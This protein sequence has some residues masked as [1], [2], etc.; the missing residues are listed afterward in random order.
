MSGAGAIVDDVARSQLVLEQD[1]SPAGAK[2]VYRHH[3]D[4]LVLVHTEVP[5]RLGGRG[6]GGQ[7][8]RAAVEQ[9]AAGGLTVVPQCSYARHW[10]EVHPDVA[11]TVAVDWTPPPG[12]S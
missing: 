2:L 8:V 12:P 7:L 9:A 4:R 11:G 3:G 1:G 6:I 10:L 5:E